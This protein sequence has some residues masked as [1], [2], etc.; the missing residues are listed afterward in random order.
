MVRDLFEAHVQPHA[1]HDSQ[2]RVGSPA[3]Q[4]IVKRDF[5]DSFNI[6][7]GVAE[8]FTWMNLPTHDTV[9]GP[10]GTSWQTINSTML[11]FPCAG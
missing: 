7:S 8:Y 4:Y 9:L 1:Y 2:S 11:G 6:P 10:H 5:F 3:Y